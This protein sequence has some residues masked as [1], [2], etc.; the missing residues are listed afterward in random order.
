MNIAIFGYYNHP[1]EGDLRMQAALV[2]WLGAEHEL[3]FLPHYVRPGMAELAGVDW[4]LI[5][6]GNLA[7]GQVGLWNDLAGW[8][9]HSGVGLG[10][11][12]LGVGRTWRE[13]GGSLAEIRQLASFVWVR[14]AFSQEAFGGEQSARLAPDL[15]WLIPFEWVDPYQEN[16][17]LAVNLVKSAGNQFDPAAWVAALE[18]FPD[19]VGIPMY[20]SARGSGDAEV[21]QRVARRVVHRF[22]P[23]TLAQ[24]RMVVSCRFHLVLYCLQMGIPFVAIAYDDKVRHVCEDAGLGWC[25][26]APDEHRRLTEVMARVESEKHAIRRQILAYRGACMARAL[27]MAE[28]C[29][30][31][32]AGGPPRRRTVRNR[33]YSRFSHRLT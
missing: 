30:G 1:S 16:G 31:V 6:G 12:G 32:L 19:A 27:A 11:V 9:K 28:H 17:H 18:A 24:S 15:S 13:I 22:D 5:G 10:V 26:L 29:Q 4:A 14:D 33:F 25:C 2:H 7:Y 8:V 23:V 20:A 21:L 3:R